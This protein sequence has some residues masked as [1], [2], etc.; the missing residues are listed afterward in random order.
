MPGVI[1]P[2]GLS[3]TR[4]FSFADLEAQGR[5]LIEQARAEARRILEVA[6]RE[7]EELRRQQFQAG[8]QQGLQEGR[9]AGLAQIRAEAREQASAEA[10]Q[11]I[12]DLTN[13]LL[14]AL[15]QFD[16]SKRGLIAAAETGLIE[17]AI[18]IA[19]R[20]CRDALELSGKIA[21]A[22]AR[23]LLELVQHAHDVELHFH[24]ADYERLSELGAA[25]FEQADQFE[26]V[27]I[28]PDQMVDRGGCVL[29][30]SDGQ[31]DA[32]LETQ[33]DRIATALLAGQV[34]TP[35]PQGSSA[36]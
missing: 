11:Q 24:P 26:H 16:Q 32:R 14:A 28:I 27:R 3:S 25:L 7:A 35:A 12:A 4:V 30:T 13:A 31:I 18:A 33:L 8:Y 29:R 36:D 15:R 5:E 2:D 9:V 34:S 1:R 21:Q 6:R 20:V 19:R 22:N 10:R 17:L 23:A